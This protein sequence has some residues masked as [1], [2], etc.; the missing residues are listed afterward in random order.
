MYFTGFILTWRTPSVNHLLS[1]YM[2]SS[3]LFMSSHGHV[4]KN[5]LNGFQDPE[6]KEKLHFAF[7]CL[8]EHV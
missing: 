2:I 5:F 6:Q 1:L 3:G 8:T 4:V 7:S